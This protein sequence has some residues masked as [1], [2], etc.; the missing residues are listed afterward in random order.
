M[1]A[2]NSESNGNASTGDV[3]NA[4]TPTEMWSGIAI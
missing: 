3:R 4:G 2:S 1:A